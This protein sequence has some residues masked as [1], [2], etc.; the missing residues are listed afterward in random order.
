MANTN[1]YRGIG[2]RAAF[3]GAALDHEQV[4]IDMQTDDIPS[5]GFEDVAADGATYD[6]GAMGVIGHSL[7]GS[8]YWDAA[9]NP[10]NA[11]PGFRPGYFINNAFIF[12]N[13]GV[14][15]TGSSGFY[16]GIA[17][18][19]VYPNLNPARFYYYAVIRC[20]Q[21]RTT[22]QIRGR[23]DFNY[24]AKSCGIIIYPIP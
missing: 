15:V 11:A 13:K 17:T 20:L 5:V 10:H 2:V 19:L 7:S 12:L 14:G 23:V 6:D 9:L 18:G 21:G 3:N 22:A 1:V 16:P 4:S 8:G 24:T